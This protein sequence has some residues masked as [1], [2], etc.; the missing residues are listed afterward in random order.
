MFK[1]NFNLVLFLVLQPLILVAEEAER[2]N[3]G[4]I[5]DFF[6]RGIQSA[7]AE[8]S[9]K[10]AEL[11][12]I[13]E[14]Y[15][16]RLSY[17][18]EFN[19]YTKTYGLRFVYEHRDNWDVLTDN[20]NHP[21]LVEKIYYTGSKI[22]PWTNSGGMGSYSETYQRSVP[23]WLVFD[24]LDSL[25]M[26]HGK[27]GNPLPPLT[28]IFMS[29]ELKA[30]KKIYKED[31]NE[32]NLLACFEFDGSGNLVE[33]SRSYLDEFKEE[34]LK[35]KKGVED[36]S[37]VIRNNSDEVLFVKPILHASEFQIIEGVSVKCGDKKARIFSFELNAILHKFIPNVI[38]NPQDIIDNYI[39]AL[40]NLSDKQFLRFQTTAEK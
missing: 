8:Y 39:R 33:F 19:N 25:M 3:E 26:M 40:Q 5:T 23:N 1:F 14:D 17:S 11:G 21:P 31:G 4:W 12:T 35:S 16:K 37:I 36:Y 9:L 6:Q 38:S 18:V 24:D 22:Q 28:G 30:I 29:D 20:G 15:Y 32:G 34:N 7:F 2:K 10:V 13:S 27:L